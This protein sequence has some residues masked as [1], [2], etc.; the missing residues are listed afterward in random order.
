MGGQD[1]IG[2]RIFKN[3]ADQDCV[4]FDF[5]WSGLDSDCKISQSAHLWY[6]GDIGGN[7]HIS[8]RQSRAAKNSPSFFCTSAA[9]NSRLSWWA[10]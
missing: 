3:F 9:C 6:F 1:W 10:V 5:I 7:V 4:G 8:R 2:L